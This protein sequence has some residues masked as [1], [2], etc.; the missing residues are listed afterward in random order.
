M[1]LATT[2]AGR[3]CQVIRANRRAKGITQRA[4]AKRLYVS[5]WTYADWEH[6]RYQM[7]LDQLECIAAVLET[8]VAALVIEA[9]R[10]GQSEEGV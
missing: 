8:R 3:I 9:E 7:H 6:G 10:A 2:F 1:T 5:Y 4:M